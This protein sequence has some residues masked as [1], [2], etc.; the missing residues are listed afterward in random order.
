MPQAISYARFSSGPQA[1]GSSEERQRDMF[2]RWLTAHP[3]FVESELSAID[4][5]KSAYKSLHVGADTALA[6]ILKAIEEKK[7]SAGDFLVIETFDRISRE[8]ILIAFDRIR[9]ILMAGIT[10]IT[11]EDNQSYTRENVNGSAMYVLVSKIQASH[12]YSKR[13]SARVKGG[14]AKNE[15]KIKTDGVGSA[16]AANRPIWINS[17]G[18]LHSEKSEMVRYAISLYKSGAGI[19]AIMKE[20][21][22]KYPTHAPKAETSIRR[23]FVN[24]SLAGYWRES[25]AYAGLITLAEHQELKELVRQRAKYG[26]AE[27]QYLLSGILKCSLCESSFNFRR[28]TPA[29]TKAAPRGSE[30]YRKKPDIVYA[31]C[32]RYLKQGTCVN[33]FTVPYEVAELV[34]SQVAAE[35]LIE[36][37]ESKA[38]SNIERKQYAGIIEKIQ[39]LNEGV[40]RL[41][42]IYEALGN[43]EDLER[44]KAKN[45]ELDA[46]KLRK[47]ELE[48][49]LENEMQVSEYNEETGGIADQDELHEE[50]QKLVNELRSNVVNL[51]NELKEYGFRINAG[52]VGGVNMLVD[53]YNKNQCKIVRRSQLKGGYEVKV[54]H[55]NDGEPFEMDYLASRSVNR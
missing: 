30:E 41:R 50:T 15:R 34:F 17:D 19:R 31:N 38:V 39:V 18:S 44:L 24:E 7:V 47:K 48:G 43:E 1:L 26:K 22:F 13:L 28:Q 33:S 35:V 23:W 4:R 52:P 6:K 3:G 37:A 54:I 40:N 46:L 51:R 10:I 21:H 27:E 12:E 29:A 16:K 8:E 20:L 32:S 53:S 5:G 49:K 25:E 36:I 11:L 2:F 45:S 55:A 42:N 9:N 14:W